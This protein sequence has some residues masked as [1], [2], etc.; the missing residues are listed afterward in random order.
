MAVPSTDVRI[1][2][3]ATADQAERTFDRLNRQLGRP[4]IHM[5]RL[6]LEFRRLD[7]IWSL[8]A[9]GS[10]AALIKTFIGMAS[11]LQK[12]QLQIAAFTRNLGEVGPIM[13]SIIKLT[14]RVPFTLNTMTQSFVRMKASGLDPIVDAQGNGPLKD[15]ADA[16][17][18]FGGGDEI[19]KRATIAIQQMAGK[20]VIS[21]EELRQQLGEAIPVAMRVMAEQM[22]ISVS[23]LITDV[24][25]GNVEVDKG[26]TALFAGFRKHFGGAGELLKTTFSGQIQ[27]A[28][29]EFEKLSK[30][31]LLDSGV[32]DQLTAALRMFNG[33]LDQFGTYLKS[34]VGLKGIYDFW[35]GLENIGVFAARAAVPFASLVNII[36][37]FAGTI[38]G[39]LGTFPPEIVGGG[40]LGFI[41]YGRA[42]IIPGAIFGL[43]SE[44]IEQITVT[45]ASWIGGIVSLIDS[46]GLNNEALGGLLGLILIGPKTGF[47]ILFVGIT[48]R[49]LR[50]VQGMMRDVLAFYAEGFANM[51]AQL[52]AGLENPLDILFNSDKIAAKGKEAGEKAKA[53][54][55]A[56]FAI[57]KGVVGE[58]TGIF[59]PGSSDKADK[60][61]QAV[62][63]LFANMREGAESVAIA[64]EELISLFTVMED[65]GGLTPKQI[66][67]LTRLGSV[68]ENL[69]IQAD[70]AG[71]AIKRFQAKLV[72]DLKKLDEIAAQVTVTLGKMS[73]TDSKVAG[74]RKELATLATMR[75]RMVELGD[76]IVKN[77]SNKTLDTFTSQVKRLKEQ[78]DVF[79]IDAE[80]GFNK[81]QN[82]V[83][84]LEN[85]F[86]GFQLR[87]EQLRRT[88][89]AKTVADKDQI[90]ALKQLDALEKT[91]SINRAAQIKLTREQIQLKQKE[92]AL[93][94]ERAIQ[95]IQESVNILS[96]ENSFDEVGLAAARAQVV[97]DGML[98]SVRRKIE[99]VNKALAEGPTAEMEEI[100]K[101]QLKHL[102]ELGAK[103]QEEGDKLIER[104]K[105]NATD[106][107]GLMNKVAASMEDAFANAIDGVVSGTKT[108]KEV[109]LDFYAEITRAVARYLAQQAMIGMFPSGSPGMGI[110]SFL[111]GLVGS[112]S[113]GGVSAAFPLPGG[114]GPPGLAMGG[115]FMIGGAGGIDQNVMS[116]NGEPVAKV[117]RGEKVNVGQ[118]GETYNINISAMDSI[119][120]QRLFM[121]H[122][123][124]LL[125]SIIARR[126]LNR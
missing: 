40:I 45:I 12:T 42:G 96:M 85:K 9:I 120:V 106:W 76:T 65:V 36:T 33:V 38:T 30:V 51:N 93:D 26:L 117:S 126:K 7:R 52:D 107:G 72:S 78:L 24:S 119:D 69:E 90:E 54:F 70:G 18:A 32:L 74:L 66:T 35:I 122:G 4:R 22:G 56:G 92:L 63:D 29:L 20:G 17:A 67:N 57:P 97:I 58:L 103:I 77:M 113:G 99:D 62:K 13:D 104:M 43:F 115:S 39:I 118:S 116:I 87:I 80:E 124:S 123:D 6:N 125:S 88:I 10:G 75:S 100:A 101:A 59:D 89:L 47:F 73:A 49:I 112:F 3:S 19:F 2:I 41:L 1:R 64:R 44:Q 111:T 109:L 108:M 27:Q 94:N 34:D 121:R 48:D 82:A 81:E 55:L 25:Q 60:Y 110:S 15:L 31:I 21:M 68:L 79:F 95:K 114:M 37:T 46:L 14:E 5:E 102:G 71:Q 23:S 84:K 50:L 16:V 8:L 105:F 83:E 28:R 86:A 53:A 11:E 91:L 61:A 98:D